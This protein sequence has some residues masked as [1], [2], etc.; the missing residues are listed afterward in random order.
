MQAILDLC[1]DEPRLAEMSAAS[2]ELVDGEGAER[3]CEI[4]D[5]RGR[6]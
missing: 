1:G 4:M 3:V 2:R 5:G 6:R